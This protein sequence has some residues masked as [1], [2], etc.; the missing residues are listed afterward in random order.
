MTVKKTDI[1][2]YFKDSS[3]GKKYW[4]WFVAL[5]ALLMI[6]GA[7]AIGYAGWATEFTVIFLGVLLTIAGILQII[8]SLYTKKWSGY[9]HSVLLAIFYVIAGILCVFKPVQSAEAITL[10]I[11]VLLLIGGSFRLF[12]ALHYRF[13]YWGFVVLNGVISIALALLILVQWPS[14]SFWV[15]GLFVGI[16]LML[17]GG[18]WVLLSLAAKKQL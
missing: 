11:A 5:G 15:I 18:S 10:L 2:I 17:I 3:N 1:H 14:S 9:S 4:G 8:S 7:L 13:E 6:L 12:N 16:D